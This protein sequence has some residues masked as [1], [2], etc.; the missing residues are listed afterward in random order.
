M[1]TTNKYSQMFT[2]TVAALSVAMC[3]ISSE[4]NASL[5]DNPPAG[6]K[7]VYIVPGVR[8]S[9]SGQDTAVI[10]TNLDKRGVDVRVE[11]F[12]QTGIFVGAAEAGLSKGATQAYTT[13]AGNFYSTTVNANISG[14]EIRFG[15][16][17][18]LTDGSKKLACTA[19]TFQN[20]FT[21]AYIIPLP[22]YTPRARMP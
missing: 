7:T 9:L 20:G 18:V 19:Q 16:G 13:R 14:Q 22:I 3:L 1:H 21:P 5:V 2:R 4:A 11:F 10:C 8:V 17:R 15:A 12:S 6:F